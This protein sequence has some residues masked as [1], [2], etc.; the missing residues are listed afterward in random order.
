MKGTLLTDW[1][2]KSAQQLEFCGGWATCWE[3]VARK[4]E[5]VS[6]NSRA[7]CALTEQRG[8]KRNGNNTKRSLVS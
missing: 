8:K 2:Y 4:N 6:C 7:L 3:V 5:R 1:H